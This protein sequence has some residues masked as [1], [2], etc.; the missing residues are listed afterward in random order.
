MFPVEERW[1]N[2]MLGGGGLA[3]VF[4]EPS[5]LSSEISSLRFRFH[6]YLRL[7]LHTWASHLSEPQFFIYEMRSLKWGSRQVYNW[8]ILHFCS[9][10]YQTSPLVLH[11]WLKD[12]TRIV[13]MYSFYLFQRFHASPWK[14]HRLRWRK[15]NNIKPLITTVTEPQ[16]SGDQKSPPPTH[17][18]T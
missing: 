16:G 8:G 7:S 13:C 11:P 10:V 17:T 15:G 12:R 18:L 6:I 3:R 1:D 9:A 5:I 2:P 14:V 4:L